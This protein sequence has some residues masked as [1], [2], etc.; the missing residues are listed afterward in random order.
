MNRIQSEVH[1]AVTAGPHR[2]GLETARLLL[3]DPRDPHGLIARANRR[4]VRAMVARLLGVDRSMSSWP[5]AARPRRTGSWRR[6][7][8]ILVS[9]TRS[10]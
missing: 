8:S 1:R 5:G 2:G 10:A 6:G 4:W 9:P 3:I 7:R